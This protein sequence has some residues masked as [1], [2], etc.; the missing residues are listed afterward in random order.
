LKEEYMDRLLNFLYFWM[1]FLFETRVRNLMRTD[2]AIYPFLAMGIVAIFELYILL[3]LPYSKSF[4]FYEASANNPKCTQK[5]SQI[6]WIGLIPILAVSYYYRTTILYFLIYCPLTEAVVIYFAGTKKEK[7]KLY[8]RFA[9][10]LQ[11]IVGFLLVL[12][13][14]YG[15][16]FL[17]AKGIGI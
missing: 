10:L 5:C 7:D 12:A 1:I 13:F 14:V 2:S 9:P 17:K 16:L 11:G 6:R 8:A 4:W 3:K 15:F